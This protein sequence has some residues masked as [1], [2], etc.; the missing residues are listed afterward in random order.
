MVIVV[1]VSVLVPGCVV[2]RSAFDYQRVSGRQRGPRC[3]PGSSCAPPP[4]ATPAATVGPTADSSRPAPEV[5]AGSPEGEPEPPGARGALA[6]VECIDL[7]LRANPDIKLAI[8]RIGQA[9]ATLD[10]ARAPFLPVLAA[11]TQYIRADAPSLFLFKSIDS[12][13]F[14]PGTDFN[15]PGTFGNFE[16][17]L[18]LRYN[19]FNGGRDRLR[20]W[21]AETGRELSEL[22]LEEAQ[23]SLTASVIDV[24]YEIQAGA[25]VIATAKASS[26]TVRAQ[27]EESE[28]KMELGSALRSDVLSLKVRLAR[29]EERVIQAVNA[30]KLAIAA[31]ANL[32]GEDADADLQLVSGDS[33]EGEIPEEYSI[34]VAEA[35]AERPELLRARKMVEQAAMDVSSRWR[36]YLPRADGTARVYWDD[37]NLDYAGDRRNWFAGVTLSWDLFAGGSR[38]ARIEKARAVLEEML[39]A[40]QKA[41]LAI[42]LDVKSAYLRIEES[43][44]RLG[45]TAASVEQAEETLSLVRSQYEAGAATVTRFLEAELML[46]QARMRYTAASFGLKKSLAD[47]ARAMGWLVSARRREGEDRG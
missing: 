32:L 2:E 26:D 1:A 18:T 16:S 12:R 29:A 28:V 35:M 38:Q 4:A 14:A 8:A 41:A 20:K 15:N 10:E 23:N 44:A 27:Y 42:Q 33:Y 40:D 43:R 24:Y 45:V 25:E 31:L 39:H 9:Q 13:S 21:M 36:A 30:R 19:L 3:Q 22:G 46:T 37:A 6:L 34:A 47:A 11:D 5:G 17:G 7:A